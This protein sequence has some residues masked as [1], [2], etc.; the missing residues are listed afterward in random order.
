M[1]NG[2]RVVVPVFGCL[3][4]GL[5]VVAVATPARSPTIAWDGGRALV[6]NSYGPV[7]VGSPLGTG[8]IVYAAGTND[9]WLLD[10]RAGRPGTWGPTG[11]GS[12]VNYLGAGGRTAAAGTANGLLV[13]RNAGRSWAP[14]S[15]GTGPLA[16]SESGRAILTTH[17]D[18]VGR[19]S[20]SVSQDAGRT[21]RTVPVRGLRGFVGAAAVDRTGD[22]MAVAVY[23][24]RGSRGMAAVSRDGGRTWPTRL[25][26]GFVGTSPAD[27]PAGWSMTFVPRRPGTLLLVPGLTGSTP[28][29]WRSTDFGRRWEGTRQGFVVGAAGG[30]ALVVTGGPVLSSKDGETWRAAAPRPVRIFPASIAGARDGTVAV[31]GRGAGQY[32]PGGVMVGKLRT[33]G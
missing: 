8:A 30:R 2:H 28:R 5:S 19:V 1:R 31:A 6:G 23:L 26:S 16:V 11:L 10:T 15:G 32:A 13:S 25:R 29:L 21:W 24:R 20:V 3:V 14:A 12:A 18:R 17:Q 22:T 4:A 33:R 7:A 27:G 9:V